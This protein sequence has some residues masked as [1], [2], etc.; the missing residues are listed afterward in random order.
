MI[1][2]SA[3][4]TA[5]VPL[6]F[7]A[8]RSRFLRVATN[9]AGAS[10]RR[11]TGGF[12]GQQQVIGHRW[13]LAGV[14]QRRMSVVGGEPSIIPVPSMGDSISEGT[15]SLWY[16]AVGDQVEADEVLCEI[17]TEKVT[18][19]IRTPDSGLRTRE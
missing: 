16:K 8:A 13:A 14:Q 1:V 2:L 17:E 19:K 9:A 6:S 18:V 11:A 15:I 12:A 3:T 7:V 5:R 4:R 10:V